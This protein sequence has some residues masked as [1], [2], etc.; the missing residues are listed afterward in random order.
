[1]ERPSPPSKPLQRHQRAKRPT[2]GLVKGIQV[3]QRA[4]P[5]REGVP[6]QLRQTLRNG[7]HSDRPAR[8]SND[9]DD[10]VQRDTVRPLRSFF[11]LIRFQNDDEGDEEA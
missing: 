11:S 9:G 4:L 10:G 3:L 6:F 1:M 5:S 2:A 7:D 8:G